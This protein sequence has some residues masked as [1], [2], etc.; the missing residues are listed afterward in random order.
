MS[1]FK[2]VV[3]QII[4]IISLKMSLGIC[5]EGFCFESSKSVVLTLEEV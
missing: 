2:E 1:G 4:F 3:E 5:I